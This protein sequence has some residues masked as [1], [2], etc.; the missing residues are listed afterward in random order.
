MCIS[1][2]KHIIINTAVKVEV[3]AL[4]QGQVQVAINLKMKHRFVFC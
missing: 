3:K 4:V 2:A 1:V